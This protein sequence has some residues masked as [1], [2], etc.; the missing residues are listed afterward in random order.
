VF[1]AGAEYNI[2]DHWGLLASITYIPLKTTSSVIVKA[3]DGTELAVSRATLKADPIIS[4]L[5]V[6]YKF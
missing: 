5:A 3:A 2:T 6:S 4:F 1:N